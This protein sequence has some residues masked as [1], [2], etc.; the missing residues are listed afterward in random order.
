MEDITKNRSVLQIQADRKSDKKD[1]E[2]VTKGV[3][4]LVCF[5][6]RDDNVIISGERVLRNHRIMSSSRADP[7]LG[8]NILQGRL[9]VIKYLNQ[10]LCPGWEY[11]NI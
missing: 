9:G 6:L 8:L 10:C 7:V 2:H 11:L 4:R 5:S 1:E 3:R